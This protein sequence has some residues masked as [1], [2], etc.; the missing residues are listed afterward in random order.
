MCERW[1]LIWFFFLHFIWNEILCVN[2]FH[3]H[4]AFFIS[5]PVHYYNFV[6]I[7]FASPCSFVEFSFYFIFFIFQKN[8]RDWMAQK[9][10]FLICVTTYVEE[11]N[12]KLP[13]QKSH[14]YHFVFDEC[15][16][17]LHLCTVWLIF[18]PTLYYKKFRSRNRFWWHLR[19]FLQYFVCIPWYISSYL[20][21][22]LFFL[23]PRSKFLGIILV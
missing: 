11:S 16:S 22:I 19:F 15:Y 3:H 18:W 14:V 21:K 1:I 12:L 9:K 4:Y 6:C 10:S 23:H 13:P 8:K 2:L 20:G 5:S 17:I 7:L